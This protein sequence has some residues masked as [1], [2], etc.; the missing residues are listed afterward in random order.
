M[1]LPEVTEE[2]PWGDIAWKTKGK[3]FAV[4]GESAEAVTVK[5]T[6]EQ[7]MALV[8]IPHIRVAKY[9]GRYGWVTVDLADRDSLEIALDLIQES[10]RLVRGKK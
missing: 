1:S 2:N 8:Q 10:Y 6:L 4:T 5:A 3:M 9:V 7:Q